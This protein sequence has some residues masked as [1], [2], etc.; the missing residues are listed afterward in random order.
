MLSLLISGLLILTISPSAESIWLP[1]P[2]SS[3]TAVTASRS[4]ST[5]APTKPSTRIWT[6]SRA[7]APHSHPVRTKTLRWAFS[8]ANT[9]PT[10]PPATS[11]TS[12]GCAAR[13]APR[14]L[15]PALQ[16]L[17]PMVVSPREMCR[18]VVVRML[19]R[20]SH[21]TLLL[22]VKTSGTCSFILAVVSVLVLANEYIAFTTLPMTRRVARSASTVI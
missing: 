6:I 11:S 12:R 17:L 16:R 22:I 5:L 3:P 1:L 13:R 19:L 7:A 20:R 18:R 2:N 8:A 15:L 4:P 14:L 21:C 9:S 10:F